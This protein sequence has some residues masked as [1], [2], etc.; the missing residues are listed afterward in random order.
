MQK[1]KNGYTFTCHPNFDQ[2][3]R[4]Y[5]FQDFCKYFPLANVDESKKD[6]DAWYSFS[7]AV[8]EFNELRSKRVR[9]H[10]WKTADESM[11]AFR[12]RTTQLGGLPNISF[13]MRK[14]EPLGKF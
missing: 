5:R 2:H 6:S 3:M 10:V 8:H 7:A 4:A 13:V 11:S 14:P 12:P 9:G 1:W